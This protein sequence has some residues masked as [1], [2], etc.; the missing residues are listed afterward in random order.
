MKK[1]FPRMSLS[2]RTVAMICFTVLVIPVLDVVYVYPAFTRLLIES[3]EDDTVVL[4]KNLSEISAIPPEVLT[5]SVLFPNHFS[6]TAERLLQENNLAK[7]KVYAQNGVVLFS[8]DPADIG[9][10]HGE[11]F[12]YEMIADGAPRTQYIKRSTDTL[13]HEH[14][15]V[16]VVESYVPIVVDG[17]CIGAFEIY[18]DVT[19][20]K[21][22]IDQIH[23]QVRGVILAV[24]GTLIVLVLVMAGRLQKTQSQLDTLSH[25]VQHSPHAVL[26]TNAGGVVEFAN[27]KF[28]ATTGCEQEDVIGKSMYDIYHA[29]PEGR[30]EIWDS[31]SLG[32]DC[33]T[34]WKDTNRNGDVL[35]MRSSIL[36][37][38]DRNGMATHMMAVFEDITQLKLAEHHLNRTADTVQSV[39]NLTAEGIFT[40]DDE[41]IVKSVNIALE[42]LFGYR[43]KEMIG[44]NVSMIIPSFLPVISRVVNRDDDNTSAADDSHDVLAR[45]RDGV[46]VP[47]SL[48]VNEIRLPDRSIL[49][50]VVRNYLN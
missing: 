46:T 49:T 12:F 38:R 27:P 13:E 21:D 19:S 25:A 23:A 24:A 28:T 50:G 47:V 3:L 34:E 8:T 15:A 2:G 22:R 40:V 20:R 17:R 5:D 10:K 16:D 36:L 11:A 41:G 29:T 39:M 44:Q 35:W 32:R 6:Q 1:S 31:I 4:A 18:Y 26:I 30:R 48:T 43:A 42:Q 45:H 7:L 37:I 33:F 9:R 14:V